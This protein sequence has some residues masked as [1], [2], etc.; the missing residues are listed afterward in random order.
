MRH[1][2]IIGTS[3]VAFIACL[4]PA[5]SVVPSDLAQYRQQ[6]PTKLTTHGPPPAAWQDN[7]PLKLPPGVQE[8]TYESGNLKLKAWLSEIP[9][10]G[11][12]R[13]AVV[14][15]HGGFWFSND[16]WDVLAP[17]VKAGFVVLAPRVRGENGNPGNFEYYYGE[18]DDVI[19]AGRYLAGLKGVDPKRVFVS[20]H[21]AGGDLAVLAAM[22]DSPFA[23]SA[24]VGAVLDMQQAVRLRDP[25]HRALVVFDFHDKHEVAERN[26]MMFTPS[27]RIPL[28]LFHGNQDWGDA[29]QKEFVRLA[30]ESKKDITLTIV[31]G[32]HG[33]SLPNSIPNIIQLFK[34]YAPPK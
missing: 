16:D 23:M 34:A 2:V 25:G 22:M 11:R 14:F 28:R 33:E 31:A 20:G 5:Q 24:P 13:P 17:F 7:T 4:A 30:Q 3:L 15:C 26:P 1:I 8:V 32:G 6:Y 29:E 27:L 18:V 21:S 12:L 9:N 10:D 19:A